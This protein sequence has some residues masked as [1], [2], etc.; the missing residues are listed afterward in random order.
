MNKYNNYPLWRSSKSLSIS[1]SFCIEKLELFCKSYWAL[2]KLIHDFLF[3]YLSL[4][5][6]KISCTCSAPDRVYW[7][8]NG[9]LKPDSHCIMYLNGINEEPS[10]S[11]KPRSSHG[12]LSPSSAN[13][14][15][16][17]FPLYFAYSKQYF[18]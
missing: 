1:V 8:I 9:H 16:N 12:C 3:L 18:H 4:K 10:S 15:L 13:W 2:S 7:D 14:Y 11:I 6:S 5:V 17:I